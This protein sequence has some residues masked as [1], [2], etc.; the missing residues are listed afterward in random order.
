MRTNEQVVP[1]YFMTLII[2]FLY[3]NSFSFLLFIVIIIFRFVCVHSFFLLVFFSY[4]IPQFK[5]RFLPSPFFFLLLLLLFLLYYCIPRNICNNICNG[6]RNRLFGSAC[7]S[8]LIR[9]DTFVI[10]CSNI[11]GTCC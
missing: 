4:S 9:F 11:L 1:Q 6:R 10:N 3:I 2:C 7:S 8:I 5:F